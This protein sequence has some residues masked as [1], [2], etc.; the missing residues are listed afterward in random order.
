MKCPCHLT[1]Y[2]EKRCQNL[3]GFQGERSFWPSIWSKSPGTW[4]S[5]LEGWLRVAAPH[6][7]ENQVMMMPY[8]LHRLG[9]ISKFYQVPG[10][11]RYI[12]IFIIIYTWIFWYKYKYVYCSLLC[13]ICI[14]RCIFGRCIFG[15]FQQ[16]WLVCFWLEF[17]ALGHGKKKISWEQRATRSCAHDVKNSVVGS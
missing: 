8:V 10:E 17:L 11:H 1:Y 2:D 14:S 13:I 3:T 5:S 15:H 4:K 7:E 16:V 12:H 9:K 6:C